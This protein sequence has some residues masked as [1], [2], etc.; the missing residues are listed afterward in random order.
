MVS[1][2]KPRGITVVVMD[3]KSKKIRSFTIYGGFDEVYSRVKK[4]FGK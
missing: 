4:A 1:T 3:R 2:Q